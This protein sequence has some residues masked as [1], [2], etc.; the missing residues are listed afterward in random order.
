[1]LPVLILPFVA[2]LARTIE[3]TVT[4]SWKGVS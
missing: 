4:L 3:R 1:M 2:D